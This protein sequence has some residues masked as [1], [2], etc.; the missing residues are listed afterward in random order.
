MGD[1][2]PSQGLDEDLLSTT[3]SEEN[4]NVDSFLCRAPKLSR[5][6]ALTINFVTTF[7]LMVLNEYLHLTDPRLL[8][9]SMFR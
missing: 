1:S 4:V 9:T 2:L 6:F 7:S 8:H 3:K 5:V